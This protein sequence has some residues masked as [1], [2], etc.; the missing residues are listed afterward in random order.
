MR[1]CH[2]ARG[3]VSE[4]GLLPPSL[5]IAGLVNCVVVWRGEGATSHARLVHGIFDLEE[6]MKPG[7]IP[8]EVE[9]KYTQKNITRQLS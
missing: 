4:R 7:S 2:L 8:T 9:K 1:P 5:Q 6:I 3:S